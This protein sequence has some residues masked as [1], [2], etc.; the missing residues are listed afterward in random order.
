MIC[1]VDLFG[2]RLKSKTLAEGRKT[3]GKPLDQ[4]LSKKGPVLTWTCF[5]QRQ[6]WRLVL[7]CNQP[8]IFSCGQDISTYVRFKQG[9][10][11]DSFDHINL[12]LDKLFRLPGLPKVFI[13]R[14][15]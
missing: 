1:I 3:L 11:A 4:A 15:L 5:S 7:P 2:L 8:E 9:F 10:S 14:E 13:H 6:C 12:G